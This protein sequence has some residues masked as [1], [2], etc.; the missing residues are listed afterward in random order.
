M[1][2]HCLARAMTDGGGR[3]GRGRKKNQAKIEGGKKRRRSLSRVVE[4][5]EDEDEDIDEDVTITDEDDVF[6][7][8]E[9]DTE[10]V[11][12]RGKSVIM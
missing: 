3:K 4:E 10:V 6:D 7:D 9:E 11:G 1:S 12:K 5:D 8:V 2:P